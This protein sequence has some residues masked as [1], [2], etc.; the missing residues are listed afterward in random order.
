MASKAHNVGVVGYGLSAKIFHIPIILSLSEFEL[1]AVVQRSPTP[2][3]DVTKDHAGV[4]GYP[5]LNDL[6]EDRQVDVVVVT[7]TPDTHYDITKAALE[8]GKHG[9]ICHRPEN[10]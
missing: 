10:C 4:R 7:T 8:A 1:Y 6:L 9:K 5:C 2:D 3:N